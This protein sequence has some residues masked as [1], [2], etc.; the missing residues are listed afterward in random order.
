MFPSRFS[1][2]GV[3]LVLYT[4]L[5]AGTDVIEVHDPAGDLPRNQDSW[6]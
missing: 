6:G 4:E 1:P 3:N 5:L 2:G